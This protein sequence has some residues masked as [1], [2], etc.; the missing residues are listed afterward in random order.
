MKFAIIWYMKKKI[1]AWKCHGVTEPNFSNKKG[2]SLIKQERSQQAFLGNNA[3]NIHDVTG[4]DPEAQ[5]PGRHTC[6]SQKDE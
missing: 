4:A 1:D 3:T 6:E 5:L 2:Q